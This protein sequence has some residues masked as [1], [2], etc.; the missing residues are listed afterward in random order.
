MEQRQKPGKEMVRKWLKAE[1]EQRR[2]PPDPEQIRR[3]LGWDMLRLQ[4]GSVPR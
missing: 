2:P 3:E 4:T 1:L